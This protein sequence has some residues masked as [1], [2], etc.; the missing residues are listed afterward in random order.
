MKKL[1]S[2]AALAV[3]CTTGAPSMLAAQS[4]APVA[5]WE[6]VQSGTPRAAPPTTVVPP[7]ELLSPAARG[8]LGARRRSPLL[9][10]AVGALVGAVGVSGLIFYEC[11]QSG[12]CIF[13]PLYPLAA[14]AVL[15]A[16]GG[17]AI[18]LGLR[19]AGK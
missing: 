3:I 18:E 17:G 19:I 15:G 8:I 10:P 4:A 5:E 13:N 14:G 16:A 12:E 2:R 7:G 1:L 11:S 6:A 9:L